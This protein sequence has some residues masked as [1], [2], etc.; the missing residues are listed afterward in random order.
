MP[1]HAETVMAVGHASA[2]P[3]SVFTQLCLVWTTSTQVG[4][5]T[6]HGGSPQH[7]DTENKPA[8]S[9]LTRRLAVVGGLS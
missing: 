1:A 9:A 2:W 3:G 4:H 6:D 5:L 8:Q 7:A